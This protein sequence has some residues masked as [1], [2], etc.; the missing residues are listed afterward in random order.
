MSYDQEY[1]L[2]AVRSPDGMKRLAAVLSTLN[3][4]EIETFAGEIS[5]NLG[6]IIHND[7]K[8]RSER[9]QVLVAGIANY[10]ADPSWKEAD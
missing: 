9:I 8:A 10:A 2:E 6:T 7:E 1:F 4:E 5:E 3:L